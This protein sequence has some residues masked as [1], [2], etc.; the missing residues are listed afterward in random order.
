MKKLLILSLI[1]LL[2]LPACGQ[3]SKAQTTAQPATITTETTEAPTTTEAPAPVSATMFTVTEH[4][5]PP[6]N[7]SFNADFKA[8][9][10]EFTAAV[11]KK[12][13]RFIDGILDDEVMSS[14]GGEP[15]K[16]YFH[17]YWSGQ[18][19][20]AAL[21]D[22]IALGGVYYSRGSE[23]YPSY[24]N[25]FVAPYTYAKFDE[26]GVDAFEHYV[27]IDK[28]VPVY[29]EESVESEVITKLDYR[30][31]AYHRD[32]G[33]LFSKGPEDFVSVT[34]LTGATGYMQKQYLRSPMDC[35]LC[36]EQKDGEWK[37]LWLIAGD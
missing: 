19:L 16:E 35:R 32:N 14:F 24:G 12:D 22:I 4:K 6:P 25:C 2:F 8:F 28:G 18:N 20:W 26:T 33:D 9:Y 21:N 27:V 15:G 5:L 31:L 11:G 3:A 1:A 10:D 29:A 13:M 37:L 23:R 17:E 34:T 7:Q 30:I 36:I